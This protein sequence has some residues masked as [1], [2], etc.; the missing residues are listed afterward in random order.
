MAATRPLVLIVDD[1]LSVSRGLSR[2]LRMLTQDRIT[3]VSSST[4]EAVA[5]LLPTASLLISDGNLGPDR[6]NGIEY[7]R[8]VRERF[9][10]LPCLLY[11]ADEHLC[12][13]LAVSR[14]TAV[15]AK[16]AYQEEIA[17]VLRT[18]VPELFSI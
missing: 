6:Q 12:T 14:H 2:Q 17:A 13:Q 1:D 15:L 10:D 9:P 7:I 8:A 18:L 11:S 3:V 16:P 5:L 4:T